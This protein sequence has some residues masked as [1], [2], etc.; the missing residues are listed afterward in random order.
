MHQ[1]MTQTQMQRT[2][3]KEVGYVVRDNYSQDSSFPSIPRGHSGNKAI[4][5]LHIGYAADWGMRF[6]Q[7]GLPL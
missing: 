5:G 6:L 2:Q 7:W 3:A 1:H 4:L